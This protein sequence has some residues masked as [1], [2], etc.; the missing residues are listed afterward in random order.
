[1]YAFSLDCPPRPVGSTPTRSPGSRLSVSANNQT[2]RGLGNRRGDQA[3]YA[4]ADHVLG[5]LVEGH[6]LVRR[7]WGPCAPGGC[8]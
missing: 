6:T 7:W 4:A 1:M 5:R 2:S 3:N 8:R